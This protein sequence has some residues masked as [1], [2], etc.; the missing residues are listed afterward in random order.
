L[1]P[2]LRGTEKS[3]LTNILQ[4]TFFEEKNF[5]LTPKISDQFFKVIDRI[6]PV[7]TV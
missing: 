1:A 5:M 6:L 3:W 4:M 2:S 7:F